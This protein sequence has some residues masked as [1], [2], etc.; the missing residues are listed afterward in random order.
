MYKRKTKDVYI[1]Q[2]NYGYGWDD[3]TF[4]DTYE[5]AKKQKKVYNENE[6]YPHRII[7]KRVKIK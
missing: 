2:G 4:E 7:V 6:N 1:V 5:E 3:L